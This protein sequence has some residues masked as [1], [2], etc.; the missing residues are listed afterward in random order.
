MGKKAK[1]GER[2]ARREARSMTETWFGS[3]W[4]T[5]EPSTSTNILAGL[6]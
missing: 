2:D 1:K 6:V 5:R 4:I 3:V